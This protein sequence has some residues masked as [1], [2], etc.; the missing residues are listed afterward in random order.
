ML[1]YRIIFLTLDGVKLGGTRLSLDVICG[2]DNSRCQTNN[3]GTLKEDSNGNY[4]FK[5]TPQ[6][7]SYDSLKA[8]KKEF[9]SQIGATGG[10][11]AEQGTLLGS[12]YEV[13]S[14]RDNLIESFAGTHDLL[15]GQIW[16]Y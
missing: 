4:F 15:G 7:T 6:Y 5:Q 9:K 8:D 12:K 2:Q 13:G 1:S 3:D 16:G 10:F 14:I 11:Q